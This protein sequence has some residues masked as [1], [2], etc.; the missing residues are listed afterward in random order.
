MGKFFKKKLKMPSHL[1]QKKATS[2][3]KYRVVESLKHKKG[4]WFIIQSEHN[5]QKYFLN[6][7]VTNSKKDAELLCEALENKMTHSM[8]HIQRLLDFSCHEDKGLC[9]TSYTI[10][11][12]YEYVHSDLNN[13]ILPEGTAQNTFTPMSHESNTHMVY[14]CLHALAY[15]TE[16]H[17]SYDD[18]RPLNIGRGVERSHWKNAS[19]H[20]V[21]GSHSWILIDRS[22]YSYSNAFQVQLDNFIRKDCNLYMSP[23]IFSGV[24]K[25]DRNVHYDSNKADVFSLGMSALQS[26]LSKSVQDCYNRKS[27]QFDIEALCRHKDQFFALYGSDNKLLCDIVNLCLEVDECHRLTAPELLNSELPAYDMIVGHFQSHGKNKDDMVSSPYRER[28]G[29]ARHEGVRPVEKIVRKEV[30]VEHERKVIRHEPRV[31]HGESRVVHQGERRVVNHG[32]T[33]HGESRVVH[34]PERRVVNH[35]TTAHGEH[36]VSRVVRAEPRTE[37][38]VSHK[39]EHPISRVVRAEPQ[40][41]EHKVSHVPERRVV[42]AEPQMTASRIGTHNTEVRGSHVYSTSSHLGTNHRANPL[43]GK[44]GHVTSHH[45]P[46]RVSTVH[47]QEPARV[48][49]VHHSSA[50]HGSTVVRRA[51]NHNEHR[52]VVTRTSHHGDHRPVVTRTSHHGE[53]VRRSVVNHEHHAPVSTHHEDRVTTRVIS[54]PAEIAAYKEKMLAQEQIRDARLSEHAAQL[55]VEPEQE[56]E[57]EEHHREAEPEFVDDSEMVVQHVDDQGP[58]SYQPYQPEIQAENEEYHD[59]GP[60]SYVPYHPETEDF[61]G[62][63]QMNGDD[64]EGYQGEEQLE[65]DIHQVEVKDG[66]FCA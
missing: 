43:L 57:V 21:S 9:S 6:K 35:G 52:P 22:G 49:T 15:L 64:H 56:F 66:E 39:V 29:E 32:S 28:E 7:Q 24:Y 26:G 18:V 30:E 25:R 65:D 54:D 62:E 36:P 14:Q 33:H 31:A 47:P 63:I 48:S 38:Q 10:E 59:Q 17:K 11:S 12:Y 42:R 61:V 3:D 46:T 23:Q 13:Q 4:D 60:E 2:I 37:H 19:D 50:H 51:P 16:A 34:Q 55:E 1:L 58:D 27:G 53:V 45:E 40:H 8:D 44:R 41:T 20:H 5:D